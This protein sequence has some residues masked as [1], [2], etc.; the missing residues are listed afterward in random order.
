MG[1][2]RTARPVI[3]VA[4]GL[5][6]GEPLLVDFDGAPVLAL[7]PLVQ[8]ATPSPGAPDELFVFA[9]PGRVRGHGARLVAE[10]HGFERHDDA[11]WAWFRR[12]LVVADDAA[13][14]NVEAPYRGL[15]T[16]TE[17]DSGLFFGRERAVEAFVN[18]LRVQPLLA[19]VGP[20]GTGKSS[21]VRAGVVPALPAGW[22][23]AVIRPGATPTAALGKL[24]ATAFETLVIVVDQLEELFTLC[25]DPAERDRFAEAL[26]AHTAD[27]RVRVVLTI[28]DDF[29]ARASELAALRDRLA[30]AVTLL[31]TPA[32]D[33]LL[34][35]LVEP[36]RRAGYDFDDGLAQ[37]MVR[38]VR[39]QPGA[40]ALL[41]FTALEL[42]SL[43]DRH[44]KRLT[45]KAYDAI[46][47]VEGALAQHAEA[48]LK[49]CTA[50]EQRL[51]REAFRHL[52][53]A[54]GT[55]AVLS[56]GELE[57]VLERSPHA[58]AVI[59]R[60]V[61]ARL[62]VVAEGDAGDERIE[63]IHEALL[64]AWPR[65]VEWRR[66]DA[67]GARLRDQ[68][69]AAARQWHDRARPR[70][71]LWRGEA[72]DDYVRWRARRPGALPELDQAFGDASMR[73][74]RRGR[75][76]R[77]AI[78][79]SVASV[80]VAGVIGLSVLYRSSRHNAEQAQAEL[81]RSY[82]HRGQQ[83]LL[84][85]DYQRA[86]PFLAAAYEG[87]DHS[88]AIRM[89]LDRAMRL[90]RSPRIAQPHG[91]F[92]DPV[93]RPDGRSV[94]VMGD[95]GSGLTLDAASGDVTAQ[96]PGVPG[97][98]S[99]RSA[100]SADGTLAA[101]AHGDT[102][103]LWDG[104]TTR[105]LS[106]GIVLKPGTSWI[107]LDATGSRLAVVADKQVTVWDTRSLARSWSQPILADVRAAWW[108]GDAVF[109]IEKVGH[110]QRI[111]AE[112]AIEL[113]KDAVRATASIGGRVAIGRA[114]AVGLFRDDGTLDRTI[115]VSSPE[116]IALSADGTRIA[117]A[118]SGSI[119]I[120]DDHGKPVATLAG[121]SAIVKHLRFA[122]HNK[123]LIS[124]SDDGTVRVWDVENQGELVR[125]VGLPGGAAG[126]DVSPDGA[127]ICVLMPTELRLLGARDPSAL[128]D[129]DAGEPV[130]AS[131]LVAGGA[132][133][134]TTSD[135]GIELWDAATGAQRMRVS[136]PVFDGAHPNRELTLAVVPLAH[137]QNVAIL[138]LPSGK[139]R[140]TLRTE[141]QVIS[142]DFDPTGSHVITA[143][144]NGHVDLWRPDGEHEVAFVGHTRDVHSA[145]FSSDGRRVVTA[146][147]DGTARVWDAMTGRQVATFDHQEDVNVARFDRTGERVIAG[148]GGR[149][150][151]I[152]DIAT[153]QASPLPQTGPV[154]A[155]ALDERNLAIA[156]TLS[157]V[158]ELWDADAKLEIGRFRH[159]DFTSSADVAGDRFVTSSHDGHVV[160]WR[161]GTFD[162]SAVEL[163]RF[164]SCYGTYVLRNDE[165]IER[166]SF[167]C[168]SR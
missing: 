27:D 86:L 51:V 20:S 159:A 49:A 33:D 2:R 125:H 56:R 145:A 28:R 67:E 79:A 113:A 123:R 97:A 114:N 15:Q 40:L 132:E 18:Q 147:H 48:T 54:E 117:I 116:G 135:H 74:A 96:L 115:D 32:D 64:T 22:R 157:G 78:A 43:R 110:A 142:A 81:L 124:A 14:A 9:G 150:L 46:G 41:S 16:F 103:L 90:A 42:W 134:F 139:P 70:G 155:V 69:R 93:F 106:P 39:G 68:L 108:A 95:D 118:S 92:V 24:E 162:G 30:N 7:A 119:T 57:D 72:L 89:M 85:S 31:A 126:I 66:D 168:T 130:G 26:A 8:V 62:V 52:V 11:V 133:I 91:L 151:A 25:R 102:I 10:P 120:Y 109:V 136:I 149:R 88:R 141:G 122:S 100:I 3:A 154:T 53:T 163:D 165:L 21:F 65:L 19:V 161:V 94:V 5:T 107:A 131:R 80:L 156:G 104:A 12:D 128:V 17:A 35:V 160:T 63:L 153:G 164:L 167:S 152:W 58:P 82:L 138:E 44:F 75:R 23:A 1:T 4:P 111:T 61:G 83:Y 38:T 101:T 84:D 36:A 55:R 146:S 140:G 73:D 127:R 45:R 6:D 60:L 143:G 112:A 121:H 87:G 34:R 105:T 98:K 99:L 144:E 166:D 77:N 59:E 137:S 76:I 71:L 50:D 47:G 29:L 158:I 129:I 13:A 148:S 37:E